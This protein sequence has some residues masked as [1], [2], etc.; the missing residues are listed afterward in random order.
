MSE[1][2]AEDAW[3]VDEGHCYSVKHLG[4]AKIHVVLE[5]YD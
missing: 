1:A 4:R 5:Y 3:R 2:L